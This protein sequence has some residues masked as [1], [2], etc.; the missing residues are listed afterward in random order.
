MLEHAGGNQVLAAEYFG[1][2]RSTLAERS[3][4]TR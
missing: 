2:S 1:V 4:N 3:N